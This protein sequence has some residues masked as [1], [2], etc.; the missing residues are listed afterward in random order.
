MYSIRTKFTLLT[1]SA[2][3]VAL[4]I[5]TYIGVYSIQTLGKRDADQMLHLKC[6][7]GA[8]NLETYFDGVERSVETVSTLVQDNFEHM[9]PEQLD[10]EV[11]SVRH[12]FNKVANNTHGVLTYYFRLDPEFSKEHPGFWYVKDHGEEFREHKVTD[13][14]QYD[15]N[16]TSALVW[17]THPKALKK[18][19]WLPPYYTE[20]LDIR[21]ISYNVPVYSHGQFVGV[22]GME[23]DYET[24]ANEV[25]KISLFE[26]G[27]AFILDDNSNIIYHPQMDSTLQYGEKLAIDSPAEVKGDH[28][29]QYWFDGTQKEAVWL[30]LRNGM[31][32]YVTVPL[33][34]INR[35]WQ[36]LIVLTL[37]VS[38]I[39]LLLASFVMMNFAKRITK[40]LHELTNAAQ[41]VANGNY[42]VVLEDN[43]N[44]EIG[45]LTRSFRGLVEKTRDNIDSL[46]KKIYIDAMTSVGN[47]AAYGAY[48]QKIQDLIDNNV[49]GLEFAIGVFDC[50][51]LKHIN[52]FY[53]HDKGDIYIKT[54][55]QLICRSFPNSPVFRIGGD[56]FAV[57]LERNDFR[58]REKLFNQFRKNREEVRAAAEHEWEQANVTMGVAVY[59]PENDPAVIDVAR[60]ADKTMYETKRLRKEKQKQRT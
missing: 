17:F 11:E 52:D 14:T 40:P 29:I 23:I 24:L 13:I 15:T 3:V 35:V 46:H 26:N 56:E 58:D 39:L 22:V 28:H 45:I 6:T 25:K 1:L 55:S 21:V 54:A 27:Y 59:D 2:I 44:D 20:N 16:D 32:L 4:C 9:P 19:V 34:E 33:G 51:N 30:P 38:F 36:R 5:A 47:K 18:G 43:G 57:I 31:R 48:M 8:M 60:R 42:D 12:L 37:S 49:E 53:G 7:S 41:Q 50:D 10:S